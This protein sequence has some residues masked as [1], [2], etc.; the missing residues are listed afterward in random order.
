[1][2][3][4]T[5]ITGN[6]KKA[7]YLEKHLWFP[8]SHKRLHLD[9]I[10]SLDIREIVEHKVRQ[11]YSQV[12]TSVLVEDV[13]LSFSCLWRLPWP[14]IKFFESELGLEKLVTLV[15][16]DNRNAIA[17]CVFS[18]YDGITVHFFEWSVS[19]TIATSP[20]WDG[21]FWWDRIFVPYWTE[22]TSAELDEVEYERFYTEE[23]PFAAVKEFLTNNRSMLKC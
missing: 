17:R 9:E 4:V 12:W 23:K 1:M 15:D 6:P 18:Y 13:G 16:Q 20:R 21:G 14:F 8:V 5:F 10:Q 19:W 22:K 11:A 7:E 3:E 2:S